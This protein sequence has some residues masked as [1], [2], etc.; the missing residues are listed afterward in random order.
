MAIAQTSEDVASMA[1]FLASKDSDFITGQYYHV[2]GGVL[3]L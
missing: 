3:M 2:D 1:Y